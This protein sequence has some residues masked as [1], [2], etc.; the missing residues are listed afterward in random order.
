MVQSNER[1]ERVRPGGSD[2]ARI[3]AAPA[4][5]YQSSATHLLRERAQLTR[6]PRM[7]CW[8]I[9]QIRHRVAGEPICPALQD[10]ELGRV[11]TE[12]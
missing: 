12:V 6:D 11:A 4:E 1:R 8:R 2:I 3:V 10:E 9:A 7:H 5:R